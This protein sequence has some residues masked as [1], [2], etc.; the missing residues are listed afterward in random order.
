MSLPCIILGSGG[1]A[2]VLMEIIEKRENILGYV[3]L[4]QNEFFNSRGV[5]YLGKDDAILRYNPK[6]VHLINGLGSLPGYNLR[7]ELDDFF[8]ERNYVFKTI[9][10]PKSIISDDLAVE[11]GVQ[12][13]AGCIIQPGVKIKR[14]SIIN[15]GAS[16]DHDC[17]IGRFCHLAPGVTLSGNVK[18]GDHVHVGTGANVIQSISISDGTVIPAGD[19]IKKILNTD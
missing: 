8:S 19:T 1:H 6:E 12:I 14:G 2:K 17:L 9:I 13:M 5:N 7:W 15:T 3:S 16:I 4:E 10:H 11:E 18:I